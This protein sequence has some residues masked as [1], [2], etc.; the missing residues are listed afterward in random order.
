MGQHCYSQPKKTTDNSVVPVLETVRTWDEWVSVPGQASQ[1]RQSQV[2]S[3]GICTHWPETAQQL[4]LSMFNICVYFLFVL[5]LVLC[6]WCSWDLPI[7]AAYFLSGWH[8]RHYCLLRKFRYSSSLSHAR[9]WSR[10]NLYSQILPTVF[11]L[12]VKYTFLHE[13]MRSGVETITPLP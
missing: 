7:Y 13:N 11:F 3:L 2:H 10:E 6:G 4:C 1:L 5:F 8:V 12:G 9:L